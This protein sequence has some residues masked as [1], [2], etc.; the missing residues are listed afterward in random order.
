MKTKKS[1]KNLEAERKGLIDGYNGHTP[2]KYYSHYHG[3]S[4]N[5]GYKKGMKIVEE[6]LRK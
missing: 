4:Y 2:K 6:N 1:S 5:R 3:R